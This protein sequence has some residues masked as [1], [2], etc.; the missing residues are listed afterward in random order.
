METAE[1]I[2]YIRG[3][4][5]KGSMEYYY[6]VGTHS[7]GPLSGSRL[8]RRLTH[9]QGYRPHFTNVPNSVCDDVKHALRT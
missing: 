8:L 3:S 6:R 1:K 7:E 2:V 4:R 5:E 9:Y